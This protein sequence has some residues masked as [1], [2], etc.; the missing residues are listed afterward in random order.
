MPDSSITLDSSDV[1]KTASSADY[2]IINRQ[3]SQLLLDMIYSSSKGKV[4]NPCYY[5]PKIPCPGPL[6]GS[7][8]GTHDKAMMEEIKIIKQNII[9]LQSQITKLP[10][11][12]VAAFL[13][14]QACQTLRTELDHEDDE[15]DKLSTV[16]DV[17][18]E[19][20]VLPS[21]NSPHTCHSART[22]MSSDIEV[23]N[24]HCIGR[25]ACSGASQSPPSMTTSSASASSRAVTSLPVIDISKE[26]AQLSKALNSIV[27]PDYSSLVS[28]PTTEPWS[29]V[30]SIE[31]KDIASSIFSHWEQRYA[32]SK[33]ESDLY[34][35]TAPIG[36][37][38]C[39]Q[40]ASKSS[41][42]TN[43]LPYN[44]AIDLNVW[45]K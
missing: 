36:N 21:S 44:S 43:I 11:Q 35:S 32:T 7:S 39:H 33:A 25:S 45:L 37:I 3:Q 27:L 28:T 20:V 38:R 16:S 2:D 41:P 6:P 15:F 18:S 1:V 26:I 14:A 4:K 9:D 34:S 8:N 19:V 23:L 12:I 17:S 22:S 5:S 42:V 30:S 31:A 10:Q 13:E 24:Y 40:E 29:Q